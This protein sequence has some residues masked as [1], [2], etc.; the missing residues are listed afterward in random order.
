MFSSRTSLRIS[1]S[2]LRMQSSFLFRQ[3]WAAMRFLLRRRTSWINSSCSD[4]SLCIFTI[5]WKSLRGRFVIWS[6]GKGSLICNETRVRWLVWAAI[7][8]ETRQRTEPINVW[9]SPLKQVIWH[10]WSWPYNIHKSK[11]LFYGQSCYNEQNEQNRRGIFSPSSIIGCFLS[12][13]VTVTSSYMTRRSEEKFQ[14]F[15]SFGLAY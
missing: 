9:L 7:R 5:I 8:T 15:N 2:R 10:Y 4:V 12:R 14:R 13:P 6:T 11:Y 1:H 3:R